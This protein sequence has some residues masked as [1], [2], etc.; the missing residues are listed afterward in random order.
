MR[1]DPRFLARVALARVALARSSAALAVAALLAAPACREAPA[2]PPEEA[3]A[4]LAERLADA[5]IVD[6]T[7]PLHEGTLVWPTSEPFRFDTL[8][9]GHTDDGYYYSARNFAGPEHGGTHLDAPIHFA[10]GRWATDDIPLGRLIGPAAVVDVSGQAARDPDYQVRVEDLTA[11]EDAH[12]PLPEGAFVLLFTDRARHFADPR[13]YMGTDARGEEAAA[14]LSFPGLHPEAARWLVERRSVSAVGLDTPSLDHGPST[15]FE[16]HRILFE[17]NVFG[18]EN[19]ANLGE[20]PPAGAVIVAL[21]ML[22]RDGT[23]GP[24]RIVAVVE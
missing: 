5:R 1:P 4:T 12:G 14:A 22:M 7:H 6:L 24:I 19:V 21:P 8:F 20:L 23:G 15:L 2:P 3:R 16:T 13:A 10:E 18:L 17:A 9:H 11:W